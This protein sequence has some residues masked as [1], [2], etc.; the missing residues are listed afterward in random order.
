MATFGRMVWIRSVHRAVRSIWWCAHVKWPG[1]AKLVVSLLAIYKGAWKGKRW[2]DGQEVSMINTYFEDSASVAEPIPLTTNANR[3]YQGSIFLGDGFLLSNEEAARIISADP[4]NRDV[5]YPAPRGKEDVNN[6]PDQKPGRCII[7]FHDWDQVRAS[8]YPAPFDIVQRLVKPERQSCKRAVRRERWW[9]YAERAAGLYKAI[10]HLQRCFISA[11]TTKYLSFSA[12][13]N[14]YVFTDALYVFTTDRWDLYAVVQLTLHDGWARKHSGALETRLR[15][16][17]S[18]CFDTFAFPGNLWHDASAELAAIGERYHEHRRQLM[19][20]LWLGLT[21]IYNLFHD[22]DLSPALVAKDSKKP[23]DIA[24]QGY[25]GLLELRR[26]HVALDLAVRDAYGW[27]DLELGHDFVEV[28]TLPE[29][30]RVR[31][32]ISPAA[33]KEVLTRL[34]QENL[35]LRRRGKPPMRHWYL[36][37]PRPEAAERKGPS[38]TTLVSLYSLAILALSINSVNKH[39][40]LSRMPF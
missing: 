12:A 19:L 24:E 25:Q 1:R 27:H 15:Y 9:Q 17:P 3:M 32:T 34:L 36:Q 11:R 29:D 23:A 33:R 31:Y 28:E 38:P 18:N 8:Q 16:S 30:D 35:R 6:A 4:R 21:D 5:I 2:R 13:P 26:L 7:N 22:R 10:R 14:N 39:I 37:S 20:K 40:S